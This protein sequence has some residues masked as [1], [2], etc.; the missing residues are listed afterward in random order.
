MRRKQRFWPGR[1]DLSRLGHIRTVRAFDDEYTAPHF[2]FKDAED[3]YHRAS[4]MRV[5][6]RVRVPALIITAE[7]DPFV[8]ADPV[9]PSDG[10]RQPAHH[11]ASVPARRALRLCRSATTAR[12]MA[13]GPSGRSWNSSERTRRR[14]SADRAGPSAVWRTRGTLPLLLMLEVDEHVP[15]R[16]GFALDRV[17]PAHDVV[18]RYSLRHAGGS[19]RNRR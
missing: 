3:Y 17:G 7:D 12:T 14:F 11:A 18:R 13:I 16:R 9:P 6:D 19:T 5:I 15:A 8:P 10:R 4:A 2:G 1:F